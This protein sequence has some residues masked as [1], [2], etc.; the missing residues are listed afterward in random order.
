[1]V[2]PNR[3]KVFPRG[4]SGGQA[5]SQPPH[6]T[7]EGDPQ[8]NALYDQYTASNGHTGTWEF[9]KQVIAAAKRLWNGNTNWFIRQDSNPMVVAYNYQF[10]LD[11][12]RFVAT[13]H[14]RVSIHAWP[15]LLSH[16]PEDGLTRISERQEIAD[17]FTELALSTSVDAILQRW[18]SQP[19][20]FDDLMV[21]LHLLFGEAHI[22]ST[23]AAV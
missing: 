4:Y 2:M 7:R 1:M 5:D 3:V 21:S 18:C 19:K 8:I 14:R 12:L 15:D 10:L 13:G 6:Y 16:N 17:L 23:Q 11:T 9:R 22:K 20:G